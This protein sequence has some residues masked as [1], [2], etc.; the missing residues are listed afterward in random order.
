MDPSFN[1]WL[2]IWTQPRTTIARLLYESPTRGFWFLAIIYGFS[3]ALNWFQSMMMGRHL[4]VM[5]IFTIA[6]VLS[7]LWGYVGFSVWS[8]VVHFTG[9]WLK[10]EGTFKEIRFAY[11]WS[12]FPLIINVFLWFVLALFFGRNLF[13]DLSPGSQAFTHGQVGVLFL[14]LLIRI[15]TAIWS[16]VIYLNALAE[17]RKFSILRAIGNV[18][19]A[20]LIIGA[21]FYALVWVLMSLMQIK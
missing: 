17:V 20:G 8:W 14:I 11:A 6:L 9:K 3:N 5:H 10:G 18:V 7:P 15:T 1:P 13:S 21:V 2:K 19:I 12:C 4:G 16:I